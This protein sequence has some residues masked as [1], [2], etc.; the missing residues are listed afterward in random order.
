MSRKAKKYEDDDG[1]TIAPMNID[2]MPWYVDTA[3][4]AQKEKKADDEEEK[5]TS[6]EEQYRQL[7]KEEDPDAYRKL[8]RKETRAMVFASL[9]AAMLVAGVFLVG[10]LL[11]ICFCVFVW[12]R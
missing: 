6:P 12:F 1:R 10:L 5:E 8:E 3:K 11:F 4:G 7:L 9:K 2:G